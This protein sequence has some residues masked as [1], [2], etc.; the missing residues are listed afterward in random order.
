[1]GRVFCFCNQQ[2]GVGKTTTCVNMAAALGLMGKRVL[3]VDLDPRG[4]ATALLGGAAEG[5]TVYE[6]LLEDEDIRGAYR[7]TEAGVALLP[8]SE[9]LGGA[10]SGLV[11]KRD[12]ERALRRALG[13]A[14]DDFDDILIDCP[15]SLG[16]L[17]INAL[18]A[19]N[20]VI[21]PTDC[22]ASA[23]A[24]IEELVKTASLV[25][26]H[27][28]KGLRLEGIVLTMYDSRALACRETE[29]ELKRLF[30]KRLYETAVPKTPRIAEAAG[31][32]RPVVLLDAKS[33]GARA[34]VALTEEFMK[35]SEGKG[36]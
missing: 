17:T 8:A 33:A 9:A 19:A 14:A 22:E 2:S 3:V 1:M 11:Y 20:G 6:A 21:V 13:P 7:F 26:L 12:G 31:L 4:C 23:A 16:L 15:P 34:Y 27:L 32:M 10:E 18:T 30:P 28:N 35:K 5:G 29:A 25:R 24:N 36:V